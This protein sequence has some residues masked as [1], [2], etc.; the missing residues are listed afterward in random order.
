MPAESGTY[1]GVSWRLESAKPCPI[2]G[3][4]YFYLSL[5]YRGKYYGCWCRDR[6]LCFEYLGELID[7]GLIGDCARP[8]L[9]LN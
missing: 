1:R 9:A 4:A 3:T 2:H 7:R 6:A 5:H 8:C